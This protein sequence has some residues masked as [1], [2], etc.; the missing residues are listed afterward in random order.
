MKRGYIGRFVLAVIVMLVYLLFMVAKGHSTP[1]DAKK[2][3]KFPFAYQDNPYQ[4]LYGS[5]AEVSI[6]TNNGKTYTNFMV[7]PVNTY[8]LFSQSV[9]F[10]GDHRDKLNFKTSDVV[11]FIYSRTMHY[12][13]CYDLTRIDVIDAAHTSHD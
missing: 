12:R 11:V 10:C 13:Y 5:V 7:H 1:A 6:F 9:T 8:L 3:P 2:S 4:Y